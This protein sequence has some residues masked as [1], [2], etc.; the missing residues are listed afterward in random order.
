M[1][2]MMEGPRTALPFEQQPKESNKAFAAFR[3]YLDMGP[4]RSLEAVARKLTKSSRLM[5]NWSSK[6]DWPARVQAHSAH[7][8][9]VERKA[10]EQAAALFGAD[11]AKR[12]ELEK[13]DEWRMRTELMEAGRKVLEK[14]RSGERGATLGDVARALDIAA[15]LGRL[16][17]GM[18]VDESE[19]ETSSADVNVLVAI[20]LALDKIYGPE[21]PAAPV[22][23]VEVVSE[24]VEGGKP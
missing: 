22:V 12:R 1:K 19:D 8:A 4:Q 20:E 11:R 21:T 6:F 17:A 2:A 9:V 5:K 15:K 14:F 16:A 10:A 24:K 7:L 3:A 23:D 18:K 13:E